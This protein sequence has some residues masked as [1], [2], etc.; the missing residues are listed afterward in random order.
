[1]T[2]KGNILV[3]DTAT[4]SGF[5]VYNA[6][7]QQITVSGNFKLK[8]GCEFDCLRKKVERLASRY[9]IKM[10][11]VE[12]VYF[13]KRYKAVYHKLMEYRG[14]IQL[15]CHLNGL[16]FDVIPNLVAKKYVFGDWNKAKCIT[17]VRICDWV[18]GYG[19]AP[20]SL[21][22]SDSIMLCVGYCLKNGIAVYSLN[23]R[24]FNGQ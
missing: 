17:K 4:Q 5:C 18:R 21:D 10:I 22:E 8:Q 1:M 15:V 14:V 3:I 24:E 23:G 19:Y 20:S 12:D 13:D 9:H 16:E 11:V 7:K 2:S 6:R